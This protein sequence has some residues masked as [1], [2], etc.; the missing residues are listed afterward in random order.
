MVEEFPEHESKSNKAHWVLKDELRSDRPIPKS[1]IR[2]VT[3]PSVKGVCRLGGKGA[4]CNNSRVDAVSNKL[5]AFAFLHRNN[6]RKVG[7][8]MDHRK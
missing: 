6:M 4:G 1:S 2:R 3:E 5:V 8:S 7:G